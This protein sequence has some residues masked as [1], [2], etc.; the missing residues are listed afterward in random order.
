MLSDATSN[1]GHIIAKMTMTEQDFE[2][3]V[4]LVRSKEPVTAGGRVALM[5]ARQMQ[6]FRELQAEIAHVREV[7]CVL[8]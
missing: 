1:A 6:R 5:H 8:G 7:D 3:L 2:L 4:K